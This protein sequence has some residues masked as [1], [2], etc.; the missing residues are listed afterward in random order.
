MS[1]WS[2]KRTVCVCV[3]ER[4]QAT[5]ERA[6]LPQIRFASMEFVISV[7]VLFFV[8]LVCLSFFTPCLFDLSLFCHNFP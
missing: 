1:I 5:N 8:T 7:L 4:V 6:L 3:S 2:Y